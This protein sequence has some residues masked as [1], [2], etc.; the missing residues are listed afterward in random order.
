MFSKKIHADVKKSTQKIQDPKKDTATR[1]R[2][3]KIIIDNADIEE[4]R[5]IFE[6]NFSHIY[7][8]L[9]ESFINAEA[10]LKQR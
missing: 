2:H 9:Y 3:I 7:F 6:A 1:L 4:A 10:T 8:V 5:H